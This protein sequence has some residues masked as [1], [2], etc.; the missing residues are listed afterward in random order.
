[1]P[2]IVQFIYRSVLLSGFLVKIVRV[3]GMSRV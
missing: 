2:S 3:F 1:M